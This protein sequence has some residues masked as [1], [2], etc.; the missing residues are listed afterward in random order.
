[1]QR[2][3]HGPHFLQAPDAGS[4]SSQ[5]NYLELQM[6]TQS[7]HAPSRTFYFLVQSIVPPKRENSKHKSILCQ[8]Y[9]RR[10]TSLLNLLIPRSLCKTNSGPRSLCRFHSIFRNWIQKYSKDVPY[11]TKDNA[12]CICLS[13][14]KYQHI[15]PTPSYFPRWNTSMFCT[16]HHA[17][18]MIC[19]RCVTGSS[20]PLSHSGRAVDAY[21]RVTLF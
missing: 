15:A 14:Q 1:M 2:K 18:Q 7:N 21:L 11:E 13:T 4:P 12:Y 5:N 20:D 10:E 6:G 19:L 16:L 17:A 3:L 9:H 8:R